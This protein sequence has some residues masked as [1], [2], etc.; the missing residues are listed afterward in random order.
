MLNHRRRLPIKSTTF[1]LFVHQQKH[2]VT[3]VVAGVIRPPTDIRAVADKTALFVAKNGRAFE[4]RIMTSEKGKTPKFAFLQTTSPFHAYYEGKIQFY[5][6]GGTDDEPDATKDEKE[7]EK[8]EESQL[9]VAIKVQ[10]TS[11]KASAIDPAA[12]ALLEQRRKIQTHRELQEKENDGKD[13][14]SPIRITPPS[15]LIFVNITAP[16]NLTPVQIETIKL[17]AQFTALDASKGFLQNLTIREWSNPLLTFLQPRHPNFA[18]F[19]AL[20]DAYK[21]LLQTTLDE[22]PTSRQEILDAAAYR[23]EY[24][25]DLAERQK[26]DDGEIVDPID[27]HDFVLVETIDFAIDEVVDQP[28]AP[29]LQEAEEEM[30]LSDEEDENIRVVRD[31]Q[32]MIKST[33]AVA[34]TQ[35]HVIDPISGKSIA[36]NDMA[37]HMRIQLLDPR[38]AEE[39]K[40]FQEKQKES[41]LV[42]G[43]D[44]AANLSRVVG[45]SKNEFDREMDPRKRLLE[46]NRLLQQ[47]AQHA[48]PSLPLPPPSAILA[49]P[50]DGMSPPSAK[51]TRIELPPIGIPL[52]MPPPSVPPGMPPG[53]SNLVGLSSVLPPVMQPGATPG[54]PPFMP[55]SVL[56]LPPPFDPIY[57]DLPPTEDQSTE[58]NLISE[59]EF[60]ASLLGPNIQLE[61]QIPH[62]PTQMAWNFYG[63]TVSLNLPVMRTVK[64]VKDELRTHLNDI[65]INKMQLKSNL[66]GFLKDNLSLAYYNLGPLVSLEMVP[67]TRVRRK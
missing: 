33:A 10:E 62:E 25:R 12:K 3:M 61:I 39:K 54:V 22:L 53:M 15:P 42:G 14:P 34:K 36:V 17:V 49:P 37:E 11:V 29:N 23:S 48:G 26:H 66:H 30:E 50:P 65:A 5:T 16:P 59:A 32:P 7:E 19:S 18:Y 52:G 31:Y 4:Q 63:Q 38:W 56:P 41:N 46:A 27:W 64:Q 2:T 40:K 24:E 67:K 44:I 28:I 9:P 51:R 43:D 35:T 8:K 60:A 47:Q 13:D 21:Q 1:L 6:N 57:T 55:P 20:T 58:E 45:N